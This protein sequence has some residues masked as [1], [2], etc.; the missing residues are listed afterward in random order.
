MTFVRRSVAYFTE[1]AKRSFLPSSSAEDPDADRQ[2]AKSRKAVCNKNAQEWYVTALQA[3]AEVIAT[4]IIASSYV[5]E[6]MFSP[7]PISFLFLSIGQQRTKHLFHACLNSCCYFSP[8]AHAC[9]ATDSY[10]CLV[11]I[12][13]KG[14]RKCVMHRHM[15]LIQ[16]FDFGELL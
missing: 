11:S 16:N 12:Y 6:L 13:C 2:A 3:K 1:I 9:P 14:T 5:F 15:G 7:N 8:Y 4:S 10:A